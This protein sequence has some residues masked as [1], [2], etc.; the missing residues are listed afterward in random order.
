MYW[1]HPVKFSSK[2]IKIWKCLPKG[3]DKA[4][5]RPW[6]LWP[7]WPWW[8]PFPNCNEGPWGPSPI[9]LT[10]SPELVATTVFW[11]DR[12]DREKTLFLAEWAKG[13]GRGLLFTL[14]VGWLGPNGPLW[15]PLTP[16]PPP[17]LVMADPPTDPGTK[18]LLIFA[19]L[20]CLIHHYSLVNVVILIDLSLSQLCTTKY[21]HH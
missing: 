12:P 20:P 7:G 10:P 11:S 19:I 8:G 9:H 5:F 18:S 6:A 4:K 16:T 17:A 1:L 14:R 3:P 15:P 2:S 21:I 13:G